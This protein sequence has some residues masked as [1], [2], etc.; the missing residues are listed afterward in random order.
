MKTSRF[1]GNHIVAILKQAASSAG[2]LWVV[3]KVLM[4]REVG[5]EVELGRVKV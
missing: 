5:S 4:E 2:V 1:K 3:A